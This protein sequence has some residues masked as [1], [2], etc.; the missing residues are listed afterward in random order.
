MNAHTQLP[1]LT[2]LHDE[3]SPPADTLSATDWAAALTRAES[4]ATARL[5]AG[6]AYEL[7]EPTSRLLVLLR[8]LLE[9]RVQRLGVAAVLEEALEA[10]AQI[11][12]TIRGLRAFAPAHDAAEGVDVHEAIELALHLLGRDVSARAS[13]RRS[14]APVERVRGSLGRL[15]RVLMSVLRNAAESIPEG[16]PDANFIFV[17]TGRG[18]DGCVTIDV[19]DTGAGIEPDDLE[20]V[21]D[22][23]FTTKAERSRTGLGLAS[24]RAALIEMGGTIRVES[25]SGHG[26]CFRIELAVEERAR[27]RELLMVP[28]DDVGRRR[29]LCVADTATEAE[30]LGGFIDD[31]D[32]RITFADVDD[33]LV[34]LMTG[35]TYDLVLCEARAAREGNVRRR[36]AP[37]AP[38]ATTRLLAIRLADH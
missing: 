5:A 4:I 22:V 8:K 11:E 26:C 35:E 25:T 29:V 33:A 31:E 19:T 36:L 17:H 24:A 16:M 20:Y 10:A 21:F 23:F 37:M 2:L 34:Q 13:V 28:S 12:E 9:S 30:R 32:A 18:E 14:Y 15:T 6:M 27:G 7:E 1:T 38:E 3:D